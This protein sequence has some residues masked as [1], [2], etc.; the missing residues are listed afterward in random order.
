MTVTST[1]ATYSFAKLA[2]TD[3]GVYACEVTYT[4]EGVEYKFEGDNE[5]SLAV[6]PDKNPK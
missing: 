2:A 5:R 3:S 1:T 4:V 6:G